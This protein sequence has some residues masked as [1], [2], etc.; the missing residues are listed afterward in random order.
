[1]NEKNLKVVGVSALLLSIIVT[2]PIML[3]A[4]AWEIGSGH[5]LF[6]LWAISPYISLFWADVAL[7][8]L[9][10]VSKLPLLFCITAL[11]MLAFTLL[12]YV[13]TLGTV[14]ACQTRACPKS[15]SSISRT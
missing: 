15:R 8:K 10:S 9:T 11:L 14:P 7:R 2:V 3:H 13:G 12:A 6:I 5:I 1:M 4:A